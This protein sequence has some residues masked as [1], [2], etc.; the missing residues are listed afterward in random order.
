MN[1]RIHILYAFISVL[2]LGTT[3]PMVAMLGRTGRFLR[4]TKLR[5]GR[6]GQQFRTP[7]PTESTRKRFQPQ[8]S[9][10]QQSRPFSSVLPKR[11]RPERPKRQIREKPILKQESQRKINRRLGKTSPSKDFKPSNIVPI[12]SK[13]KNRSSKGSEK[14]LLPVFTNKSRRNNNNC[15][16]DERRLF[17]T[18]LENSETKNL[19]GKFN[20]INDDSLIKRYPPQRQLTDE[21]A[22]L[23]KRVAEAEQRGW[24]DPLARTFPREQRKEIQRAINHFEKDPKKRANMRNRANQ[25]L[26]DRVTTGGIEPSVTQATVQRFSNKSNPLNLLIVKPE[27][28]RDLIPQIDKILNISREGYQKVEA[29]IITSQKK[30]EQTTSQPHTDVTHQ[31]QVEHP[32]VQLSIL[33]SNNELVPTAQNNGA[34]A[35]REAQSMESFAKF[36]QAFVLGGSDSL[37]TITQNLVTLR[38]QNSNVVFVGHDL[39]NELCKQAPGLGAVFGKNQTGLSITYDTET[40]KQFATFATKKGY[41]CL[42]KRDKNIGAHNAKLL[43]GAIASDALVAITG[44][45][46]PEAQNSIKTF[47]QQLRLRPNGAKRKALHGVNYNPVKKINGSKNKGPRGSNSVLHTVKKRFAPK[48]VAPKTN[49]NTGARKPMCVQPRQQKQPQKAV[50]IKQVTVESLGGSK[51]PIVRTKPEQSQQAVRIKPVTVKSLGGSKKPIVYNA[52]KQPQKAVHIE[53]VTVESLGGSKKPIAYTVPAITHKAV[54]GFIVVPEQ[55]TLPKPQYA[56]VTNMPQPQKAQ[57]AVQLVVEPKKAELVKV[58]KK[59]LQPQQAVDIEP[60]R[61]NDQ[62][63]DRAQGLNGGNGGNDTNKFRP[64]NGG[65]KKDNNLQQVPHR[66]KAQ[67]EKQNKNVPK[68][69]KQQVHKNKNI[70]DCDRKNNPKTKKWDGKKRLASRS[71]KCSQGKQGLKKPPI[72]IPILSIFDEDKK[73]SVPEETEEIEKVEEVEETEEAEKKPGKG[74]QRRGGLNLNPNYGEIGPYWSN[75]ENSGDDLAVGKPE[76]LHNEIKPELAQKVTAMDN[77][78]QPDVKASDTGDMKKSAKSDKKKVHKPKPLRIYQ[79]SD[80]DKKSDS[81]N[82]LIGSFGSGNRNLSNGCIGQAGGLGTADESEKPAEGRNELPMSWLWLLLA[83]AAEV[84][85]KRKKFLM[86]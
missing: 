47:V 63:R 66:N 55:S 74:K 73:K 68:I 38:E 21:S 28:E 35:A 60:K 56:E 79:S 40:N 77:N 46:K 32:N 61:R 44:G 85:S 48:K 27:N 17:K 13:L 23:I 45:H 2:A 6:G 82:K 52:P 41:L 30:S 59:L 51:K 70:K 65:P 39:V 11:T 31:Q 84:L 49:G 78:E 71:S 12:F 4:G 53:P 42:V 37:E 34:L 15:S 29:D 43:P 7:R 80:D 5:S 57:K 50:R 86:G 64:A 24:R 36:A 26:F 81:G 9:Y 3:V 72:I 62:P 20:L 22:N 19:D 16:N 67:V 10:L 8:R 58:E 33:M 76:T 54:K 14:N 18:I 75:R 25:D 83:F 1:K 69:T